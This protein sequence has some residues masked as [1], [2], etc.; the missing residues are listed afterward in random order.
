M[1]PQ[2]LDWLYFTWISKRK[3]D[4]EFYIL[5]QVKTTLYFTWYSSTNSLDPIKL[6]SSAPQ[7]N[8]SL[9]SDVEIFFII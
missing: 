9:S 8:M 6:Y 4:I 7:L 1:H 3:D 2:I 5:S